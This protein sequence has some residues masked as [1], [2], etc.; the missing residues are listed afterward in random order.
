MSCDLTTSNF[1]VTQWKHA[2]VTL[3]PWA[4]GGLG[5]LVEKQR[6]H[7]KEQ[8]WIETPTVSISPFSAV[9]AV[10]CLLLYGT[11]RLASRGK[12]TMRY[13]HSRRH[14]TVSTVMMA[15]KWAGQYVMCNNVGGA[16]IRHAD[17]YLVQQATARAASESMRLVP[18][19]SILRSVYNISALQIACYQCS[20][21]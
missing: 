21:S 13:D 15:Q 8:Y 17:T 18:K 5:L 4:T 6:R 14:K 11:R 19:M 20:T 9:K 12:S 3:S 10:E 16:H 2:C 7:D 1:H